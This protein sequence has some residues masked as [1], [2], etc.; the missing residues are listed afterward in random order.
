MLLPKQSFAHLHRV[1]EHFGRFRELRGLAKAAR[2]VVRRLNPLEALLALQEHAALQG[3]G[4]MMTAQGIEAQGQVVAPS[5][6]LDPMQ[7]GGLEASPWRSVRLRVCCD[8]KRFVKL[9]SVA[10]CSLLASS[11]DPKW[12]KTNA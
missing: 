7:M 9:S 1:A 3:D 11:R 8:P 5:G 2:Q 10:T 12:L 4:L 6:Q